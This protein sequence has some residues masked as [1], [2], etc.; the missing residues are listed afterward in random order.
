MWENCKFVLRFVFVRVMLT[1]LVIRHKTFLTMANINKYFKEAS[2]ARF[3]SL[4]HYYVLGE[5]SEPLLATWSSACVPRV[6]SHSNDDRC[7]HMETNMPGSPADFA[8]YKR[9]RIAEHQGQALIDRDCLSLIT[10]ESSCRID[11]HTCSHLLRERI[12]CRANKRCT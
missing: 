10:G 4:I 5:R 9:H 6:R 11:Y 12:V 8:R 1:W 7:P 2:S 3:S